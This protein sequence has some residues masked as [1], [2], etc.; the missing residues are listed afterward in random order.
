MEEKLKEIMP[1]FSEW[2]NANVR[3][4][5]NVDSYIAYISAKD[6]RAKSMKD[7][8]QKLTALYG[9]SPPKPKI[10]YVKINRCEKCNREYRSLKTF[11]KHLNSKI[12]NNK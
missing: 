3:M 1:I 5:C 4:Q 10:K 9:D 6:I 2:D 8:D 12:H 11:R 7:L